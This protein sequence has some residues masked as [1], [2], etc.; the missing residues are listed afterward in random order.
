[1][2]LGCHPENKAGPKEVGN[3]TTDVA[4][5]IIPLTEVPIF[6]S[7]IQKWG[8]RGIEEFIAIALNTKLVC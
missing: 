2:Q 1:M 7:C 8:F 6:R 5:C 3:S 4:T